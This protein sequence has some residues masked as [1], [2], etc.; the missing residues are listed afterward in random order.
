MKTTAAFLESATVRLLP[1]LAAGCLAACDEATTLRCDE[2]PRETLGSILRLKSLCPAYGSTAITEE[3]T[4]RGTVTANDHYGEFDRE[5]VVEDA[6]GAIRIAVDHTPLSDL[7]PFGCIVTVQCNGLALGTYGGRVVLGAEPDARYGATRIPSSEI[8]RRI[9]CEG[10][11]ETLQAAQLTFDA[12]TAAQIDT[13]VRCDGV[14]FAEPGTWCD[15]DPATQR[16][17]T[18]ERELVDAAGRRFAVRT[19]G[20][21]VYA[22]EPVPSGTGSLYGI[23]DYFDGRYSLRVT[24]HRVLYPTAAAPPTAY[25]S[26]SGY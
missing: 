17:V 25:P 6:S 16:Y 19:L 5:I 22:A 20:T 7:F 2:P 23:V 10:Q 26:V 13:Y 12:V 15:F 11:G 18:T 14:R 8:G 1:V 24:A 9:R 4:I 3:I 21:C